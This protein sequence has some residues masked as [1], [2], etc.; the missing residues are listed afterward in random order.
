MDPLGVEQAK[1]GVAVLVV[2]ESKW[3]MRLSFEGGAFSP[4]HGDFQSLW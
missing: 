4:W 2:A 1:G 3:G